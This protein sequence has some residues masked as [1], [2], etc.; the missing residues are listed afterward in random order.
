MSPRSDSSEG[1]DEDEVI[2]KSRD[3]RATEPAQ[4]TPVSEVGDGSASKDTEEQLEGPTTPRQN[5]NSSGDWQPATAL[6]HEEDGSRKDVESSDESLSV[7]DDSPSVVGSFSASPSYRNQ[8][9]RFSPSMTSPTP[10]LRPFDRR[11]IARLSSSP[12]GSPRASSPAFLNNHSRQSSLSSQLGPFKNTEDLSSEPWEVIRWAKLKKLT[13]QAYSEVGKGKFGKPTCLTASAVIVLGT[14]R[15]LLLVFDYLQNLQAIIGV[16]T[17]AIEAG[18]VTSIALS[19]DHLTVASGHLDGSIFTW[20]IAKASQPF[21]HIPSVDPSTLYQPSVDGHARKA[22]V[23]HV[24]FLGT[25]HTALVSADDRGMAFSHLATRGLGAVGRTVKTTRILGRYPDNPRG[26]TKARKPSSVLAFSPL[27]L[28]S[29]EQATDGMGVVALLTPYLLVIVS[30]TPIAQ[31]QFKSPRPKEVLAHG[32]MSG[33]LAWFPSVKIKSRPGASQTSVSLPKLVYCWSNVLTILD[34]KTQEPSDPADRDRPP[35]LE[36]RPRSRWKADEAIVA[37]QWI[38]RSVLAVLTITQQLKIIEDGSL[39]VTESFDLMQRQIFHLDVFSKQLASLVE[40]LDEEDQSMHGVVADAFYS[41]FRSYKGRLF[42]LGFNDISMGTLSNWADRLVAFVENGDYIA[43]IQL[44]TRYYTG[45]TEKLTVGLPDDN[46]LRHSIVQEKLFDMMTA[47]LRYAFPHTRTSEGI[48]DAEHLDLLVKACFYACLSMEAVEYLLNDVFDA[49]DDAGH[50]SIFVE[51]LE[52]HILAEDIRSIPAPVLQRLV[53]HFKANG[54]DSRLEELICQLDTS[55]MNLDHIT[56]LCKQHNL[57]DALIYVWNQALDDYTTP[58]VELFRLIKLAIS[59]SVQDEVDDQPDLLSAQKL[60]PYLAY[61]LTSRKYPTGEDVDETKSLKAKADLYHILFSGKT[62]IWPQGGK[63]VLTVAEGDKE[64]SFPYLHLILRYDAA[65]FLSAMNEAFEDAFLNGV[66]D[67]QTKGLKLDD[68]Q[69]FGITVNRQYVVSILLEVMGSEDFS[70]EDTIYLDM[71]IA[72]NLPKFPQFILLSG[73]A[74]QRVLVGLCNYPS[75]DI[76][77]DCQLSVEYLLSIH[78][79]PD[80]NSL[81]PLFAKAKFFR[82]LKSIFKGEKQYSDLIETFFVDPDGQEDVFDAVGDCLR[83]GSALDETQREAVQA[84]LRNHAQQ[85]AEIE[86]TRAALTIEEYAPD[87]HLDILGAVDDDSHLEYVYLAAIL[88]N[89]KRP[90]RRAQTSFTSRYVRL[91]CKF[92]PDRVF[93][94]V[95][96]MQSGDLRLEDVLPALEKS[97]VVDAAV[98]LMAREGKVQNAMSRLTDHLSTL[99]AGLHGLLT[100]LGD[101]SKPLEP[102][103]SLSTLLEALNRYTLV[104]VW[105]CQGQTKTKSTAPDKETSRR[106]SKNKHAALNAEETIWLD[107]LT[108]IIQIT[109]NVTPATVVPN[110]SPD[111]ASPRQSAFEALRTTVQTAFSAL[112]TS[113]S[114]HPTALSFLAILRALLSHLSSFSPTLSSLRA[115]LQSIFSAYAHE[116]SLLSL[117]SRLLDTSHYA[118]VN[119]ARAARDAGWRP[120]SQVCEACGRRVW[121]PGA[122]TAIWDAWEARH[123]M[124]NFKAALGPPSSTSRSGNYYG[125]AAGLDPASRSAAAARSAGSNA[126]ARMSSRDVGRDART[127]GRAEV[128]GKGKGRDRRGGDD[129]EREEPIDE[130]KGDETA[131]SGPGPI[132]VF[133][134]RH[135]YHVRC[136]ERL[137]ANGRAVETGEASGGSGRHTLEGWECINCK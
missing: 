7:P 67:Q 59:P 49:Y 25:R 90:S 62:I 119:R 133:S 130:N 84:V 23:I 137:K 35:V 11:F 99:E 79:P 55:T 94:Y 85:F 28:G 27:P 81:L 56:A 36:F 102:S 52:P 57:Y 97:G 120:R 2:A 66:S 100:S 75:E 110:T 77:E 111:L 88:K 103:G 76:A 21:L 86:A 98:V 18:A 73:T 117:A 129:D 74:L 112:L 29:A 38:S 80:L 95:S 116:A 104:G 122:G 44:A 43:A 12:L 45:E 78:R 92:E 91:M 41:S 69:V 89:T 128:G 105:L 46:E 115:V 121:G 106:S 39:K 1:G 131:A 32:A 109:R 5:G 33:C 118:S 13:G 14:D 58:L 47:S 20:E 132:L 63:T 40:T 134:C 37:V 42:L 96:H 26:P 107:L 3:N 51:A 30:T 125:A 101:I 87:L 108:A 82:V 17:K 71:F 61:V 135:V 60:F 6:A 34:V 31:T 65:S 126:G 9:A 50:G 72:R 54:W 48:L 136:L 68:G 8:S 124:A 113:T 19:A 53:N 127:D 10:S 16:G 93:E 22:S 24:G 4:P 64:P 123:K 15:G 114:T 70:S 83:P